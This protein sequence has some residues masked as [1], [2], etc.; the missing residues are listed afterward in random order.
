[1]HARGPTRRT[2]RPR[3]W[4]KAQRAGVQTLYRRRLVAGKVYAVDGSGLGPGGTV[5]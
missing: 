2:T 5:E 1:M 4:Q 3:A